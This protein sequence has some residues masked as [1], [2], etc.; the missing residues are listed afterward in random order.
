[1][2]QLWVDGKKEEAIRK[3]PE[4]MVLKTN[5]IGTE[6]MIRERLRAYRDA[7]VTTLRLST[8]GRTWKERTGTLE[9]ALDLVKSESSS[10]SRT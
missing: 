8:S 2:Q 5:M 6:D 10:W 4:E 7:G 3:V 9:Q 1:M